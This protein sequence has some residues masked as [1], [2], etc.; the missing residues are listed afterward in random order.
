M[1][2]LLT[3]LAIS[4]VPLALFAADFP[5][6]RTKTLVYGDDGKKKARDTYSRARIG[7]KRRLST[8]GNRQNTQLTAS[9]LNLD[10][11]LIQ[12]LNF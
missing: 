1:S 7:S 8:L 11:D 12:T 3:V 6:F 2:R 10:C 5:S 4:S 9:I